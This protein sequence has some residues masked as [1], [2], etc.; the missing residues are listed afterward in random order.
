MGS[1]TRLCHTSTGMQVICY[2]TQHIA[3]VYLRTGQ[4]LEALMLCVA[5]DRL[6]WCLHADEED[7]EVDSDTVAGAEDEDAER[8][9]SHAHAS[10]SDAD[11]EEREG[12]DGQNRQ[13]G[14]NKAASFARAFAKIMAT[15]TT[16][17]GILSVRLLHVIHLAI[18]LSYIPNVGMPAFS[19]V[20]GMSAILQLLQVLQYVQLCMHACMRTGEACNH[21][22]DTPFTRDPSAGEQER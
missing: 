18:M 8:R 22:A 20:M 12:E 17:K 10:G 6:P 5:L 21:K 9:E 14:D 7:N 11:E 13:Q 4:K 1:Q 2:N 16:G 15:G 19:F 3:N